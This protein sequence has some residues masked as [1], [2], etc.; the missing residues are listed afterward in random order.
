MAKLKTFINSNAEPTAVEMETSVSAP[1]QVI[2]EPDPVSNGASEVPEGLN[3]E[4][5]DIDEL[6][7]ITPQ[8]DFAAQNDHQEEIE[9]V[10][11]SPA[12]VPE[13]I[14][15]VKA[16]SPIFRA[17]QVY[18]GAT[19]QQDEQL[20]AIK[21]LSQV[22][23]DLANRLVVE[24]QMLELDPLWARSQAVQS[25]TAELISEMWV[26]LAL[27]DGGTGDMPTLSAVSLMELVRPVLTLPAIG[28]PDPDKRGCAIPLLGVLSELALEIDR[29]A[30][31]VSQHLPLISVDVDGVLRELSTVIVSIVDDLTPIMLKA[32]AKSTHE[33][34]QASLVTECGRMMGP[35]WSVARSVVYSAIKDDQEKALVLVQSYQS[36][37]P[38]QFIAERLRQVM[39]QVVS[40]S[41]YA[42][43]LQAAR[44]A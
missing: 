33:Q 13:V 44:T 38:M 16:L 8:R 24:A 21:H 2:S 17:V 7:K 29:Y 43:S 5:L 27:L 35:I 36:G 19:A 1:A 15:L 12:S 34:I 11:S 32:D 41:A 3:Q 30:R 40:T 26:S 31:V 10:F 39:S 42:L 6:E 22:S 20:R 37:I 4:G 23:V 28:L 9:P 18:P 25:V 14:Q